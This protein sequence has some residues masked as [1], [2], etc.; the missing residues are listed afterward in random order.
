M[1]SPVPNSLDLRLTIPARFPGKE[2]P[3]SNPLAAKLA[4]EMALRWEKGERPLAE[5]FLQRHPNLLQQ[6]GAVLQL[7]CEEICLRQEYGESISLSHYLSRFP[8]FQEQLNVL[9][10]CHRLFDQDTPDSP[11]PQAGEEIGEYFL[12]S[13]LGR[14]LQ[15]RVILD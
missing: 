9:V 10:G 14:G 13:E 2:S 8:H 6:P 3:S 5:E 7:I 11:F 1:S 15:S 12:M 4:Q